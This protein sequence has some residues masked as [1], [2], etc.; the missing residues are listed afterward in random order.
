MS[1][2]P[3]PHLNV[4]K[5][6]AFPAERC[7]ESRILSRASRGRARS[8]MAVKAAPCWTLFSSSVAQAAFCKRSNPFQL[9]RRRRCAKPYAA[10]ALGSLFRYYQMMGKPT[11]KGR[12]RP[13]TGRDPVSAIRLPVELTTAID[14]WAARHEATSRSDAIRRLVE[15][16]LAGSQRM[17]Q[18]RSQAATKA[19]HLAGQQI[20]KLADLSA[21]AEERQQ[22]KRRLLK[23]PGEFRDLRADLPKATS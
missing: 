4:R 6:A 10:L 20:D 22:R 11:R 14:K 23:G 19:S 8:G 17:R 2:T 18:R 3:S 9:W 7:E 13:A 12:G 5:Q 1:S 16:G 21:T 15:L